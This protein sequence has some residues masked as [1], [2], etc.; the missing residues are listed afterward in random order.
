MKSEP[1]PVPDDLTADASVTMAVIAAIGELSGRHPVDLDFCLAEH[2]DPD[3]LDTLFSPARD[4]AVEVTLTF[5]DYE[6]T[7]RDDGTD[8]TVVARDGD[9]T[10]RTVVGR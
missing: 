6:V 10:S 3:A 4:R 8:I 1:R 5:D 9:R 2:V 7:V